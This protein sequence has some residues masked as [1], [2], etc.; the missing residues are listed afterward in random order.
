MDLSLTKSVDQS[1]ALPGDTLTYSVVVENIGSGPATAI[2]LVDTFPDDTTETRNLAEIEPGSS[3][4]EI[5][6]Y[7]VPIFSSG[8][9]ITNEA[10]V[11]GLDLLGNPDTDEQNDSSEASTVVAN[12]CGR[13]ISQYNLITGTAGDDVLAGGNGRNLILGLAGDDTITGGNADDCIIG[14]SGDDI[15]RGLNGNDFIAG[16]NGDD[17]LYGGDG[18]DVLAGGADNDIIQGQNGNDRIDASG[19]DDTAT[20]G[21]GND[22]ID[23]GNGND[24]CTGNAGKNSITN[25]SP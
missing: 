24:S 1:N 9:T 25:C 13:P 23:G 18:N 16:N 11:T 6:T 3:T 2:V 20:G 17:E 21:L 7:E 14:G 15:I 12:F 5:F 10:G 8:Q 4:T 22:A 19:G